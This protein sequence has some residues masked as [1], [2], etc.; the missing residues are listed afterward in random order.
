MKIVQPTK[1]IGEKKKVIIEIPVRFHTFFLFLKLFFSSWVRWP[2]GC[3]IRP[4]HEKN[5][6]TE[7]CFPTVFFPNLIFSWVGWLALGDNDF[8]QFQYNFYVFS[9]PTALGIKNN[10]D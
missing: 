4:T 3:E 5:R 8:V 6:V 9:N 2:R 1:K 10:N 7:I